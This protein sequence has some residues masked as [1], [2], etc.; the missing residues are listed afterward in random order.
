MM[1]EGLDVT[2]NIFMSPTYSI[3]CTVCVCVCISNWSTN[4]SSVTTICSF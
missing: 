2:H 3:G 1:M 4:F